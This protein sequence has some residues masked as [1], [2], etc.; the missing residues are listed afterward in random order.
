MGIMDVLVELDDIETEE[1]LPAEPDIESTSQPE[2]SGDILPEQTFPE[3]LPEAEE[4]LPAV[5]SPEN[6]VPNGFLP[7]SPLPQRCCLA[8]PLC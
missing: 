7:W 4:L 8:S 2:A 6:C 5:A 1:I 3:P